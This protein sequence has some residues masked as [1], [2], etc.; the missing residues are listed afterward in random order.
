MTL[1][2]LTRRSLVAGLAGLAIAPAAHA[3]PITFP[4][5][6]AY[7][8][9]GRTGFAKLS[10]ADQIVWTALQTRL[11]ALIEEIEPIQPGDMLG[12]KTPELDGGAS[13]AMVARQIATNA[14]F[15]HV[16]LY[17]THDG[18]RPQ[19]SYHNWMTRSFAAIRT[20]YFEYDNAT[21]EAHLLEASGGPAIA[22]VMADARKRA[23]L[24]VLGGRKPEREALL[25]ITDGLE[26]KLQSMA[27]SQFEA[28][29]SIAD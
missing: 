11:G 5:R 18:K 14:G 8:R 24:E 25:R 27:R 15:S 20:E 16:I 13:C 12:A 6:V 10:S 9:I 22:S 2:A 17:A 3:A 23:P 28:Q 26:R 1:A 4:L 21:G 7:A 19:K 29:R